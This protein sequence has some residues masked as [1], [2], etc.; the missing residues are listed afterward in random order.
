VQVELAR[1]WL[2]ILCISSE[3]FEAYGPSTTVEDKVVDRRSMFTWSKVC[4][5]ALTGLFKGTSTR[6]GMLNHHLNLTTVNPN[7]TA[8]NLQ[9]TFLF[10]NKL[11]CFCCLLVPIVLLP[12]PPVRW[13]WDAMAHS[14]R[15][16][17]QMFLKLFCF[18]TSH[19][20]SFT[21]PWTSSSSGRV[22][23]RSTW[24]LVV[25]K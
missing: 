21:R 22:Y 7:F 13:R 17:R 11:I 10:S 24:V 16:Q 25:F 3:L 23:D 9:T 5:G 1:Y 8:R 20:I 4:R 19:H 14:T 12:P 18:S 15:L 2:L 6:A